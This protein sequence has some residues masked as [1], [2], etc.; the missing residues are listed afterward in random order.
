MPTQAKEKFRN[1]FPNIEISS[2]EIDQYI[3]SI[4]RQLKKLHSEKIKNTE[5]IFIHIQNLIKIKNFLS[6]VNKY[7]YIFN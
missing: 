1:K 5:T 3:R 6:S 7:I 4:Y 2:K